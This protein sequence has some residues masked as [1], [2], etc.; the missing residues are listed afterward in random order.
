[1][2]PVEIKK[3]IYWVG[4]IDW[5]IR[6]FHGP[7]YT[8]HRGTTYNSYLLLDENPTLVD[9]VYPPFSQDLLAGIRKLIDPK[10][11]K[12]VVVNHVEIDHSGSLPAIME[13]APQATI[14]CSAKAAPAIDKHFHSSWTKQIVNT[15]DTVSIGKRTLAFVEAP[16][17]HWPD[18]MFTY[19]P[20]EKLLLPNDAFGMH[21]ATSARFDDEVDMVEV[22]QEARKYYANILLPF[23]PL[24]LKKIDEVV[25]MGIDI[26]MIAP[27]HG[28]IWRDN[29]GRII[30]AYVEWA[31]GENKKK[32][33][34]V[35]DTMWGATDKLA[36]AI[37]DGLIKGGME[38]NLFRI[39]N[40]DRNDV[41]AMLIDSELLVVGS[42]TINREFLASL[43]AFLDDLIGLK[44]KNKRAALFGSSGWSGGAVRQMAER[45]KKAGFKLVE[46]SFEVFWVPTEE[47]LDRCREYGLRLA[48]SSE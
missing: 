46:D 8:T 45:V 26:D 29:P 2:F 10:E 48:Q 35:Y 34:V 30:N 42:P 19:V 40:S 4:T 39:S 14:L 6:Y 36:H 44:P 20:E 11:L 32:A 23:S 37:V 24:V 33:T 13:A 1:M 43:S 7:A 27:S 25:E 28:I 47:E 18:S 22:M 21:I 12:Y 41:V 16:M 3:D 38:V 17:L 31:K 5:N 15:G 9:T